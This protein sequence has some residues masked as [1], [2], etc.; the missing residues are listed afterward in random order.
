MFVRVKKIKGQRYGYLV[1]NSWTSEGTRQK[2]GKYLGRVHKPEKKLNL[3]VKEHYG[4]NF[5]EFLA[6]KELKDILYHIVLLELH[7]HGLPKECFD[8]QTLTFTEGNRQIVLEINQGFLCQ[9]TL[10]KA[11][12]YKSEDD[13]GFRL[14]ELLLGAGLAVEKDLFVA[15]F[16][17]LMPKTASQP[18]EEFYY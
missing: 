7:N 14:A 13:A 5:D 2:V 9:A 4:L 6:N 15:L 18:A 11:L 1:Q 17:K 8:P 3:T 12:A 10:E 16:E